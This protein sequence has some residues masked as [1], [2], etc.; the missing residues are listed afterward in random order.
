MA[1]PN[2]PSLGR[3]LPVGFRSYLRRPEPVFA[4]RIESDK[5]FMRLARDENVPVW[6]GSMVWTCMTAHGEVRAYFGD[7]LVTDGKGDWWPVRAAIFEERYA[8]AEV[9]QHG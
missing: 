8:L 7:Y 4:I 5:D 1:D 9:P 3:P 6:G 2:A